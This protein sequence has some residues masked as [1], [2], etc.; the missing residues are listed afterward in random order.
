MSLT[1]SRHD[2]GASS[3]AGERA[4]V[5]TG[6]PF[7]RVLATSAVL[8]LAG[9]YAPGYGGGPA[10]YGDGFEGGFGEGAFY[11]GFGG[12]GFGRGFRGGYG[13]GGFGRGFGGHGFGGH[14]F[15]GGRR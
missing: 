13:A 12:P 4:A 11:H 10:F 2:H 3:L 7:W 15:G 9:C 6:R 1:G 5:M 14:G 8:A